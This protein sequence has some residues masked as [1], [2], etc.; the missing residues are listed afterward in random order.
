MAAARRIRIS[1]LVLA[2]ALALITLMVGSCEGLRGAR[3]GIQAYFR[4]GTDY[5]RLEEHR[6]SMGATVP[7]P[8][9]S[10]STYWSDFRGPGR[11]GIYDERPLDLDWPDEGP[12]RLW[13][14]PIGAG[15]GSFTMALGLAFT[16]EQRRD[17]EAVVA[18][19]ALTGHEAWIHPYS[20]RHDDPLGGEGPRSTPVYSNGSVY[21]LGATGVLSC[22]DAKNGEPRWRR[23]LLEDSGCAVPEYGFAASPLVHGETLIVFGGDADLGGEG[24]MAYDLVSGEPLWGAVS[25]RMAYASP[26][27]VELAGRP[28]LIAFTKSRVLGLDPGWGEQ[29]WEFPWEVTGGLACAQP[30]YI[31]DEHLLL[32]GGYGKGAALLRIE[33][34]EQGCKVERVWK[35]ARL[36][37]RYNSSL[38]HD[39]FVYGLDE[40]RLVCIDPLSGKRQWKASDFGYGQLLLAQGHLIVLSEDGE[41]TLVLATPESYQERA[42][43]DAID[44]A[45]LNLPALGDGLL[46]VR[47]HDEMAGFDLR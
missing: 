31:D 18:Y 1:L 24:V 17:L 14:Q 10:S 32:S 44:G 41:V 39:G 47:N 46:L 40:G 43:F 3:L 27:I 7:T 8:M 25:E 33:T 5:D 12:P 19:D 23:D 26:M 29:L 36:K 2:A 35:N 42:S 13:R 20:A 11:L 45:T 30:V 28:Q 9:E 38:L 34:S 16:L 21:S 22:L 4:K 37:N 6:A 15:Y